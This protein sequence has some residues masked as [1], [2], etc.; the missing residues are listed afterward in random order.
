MQPQH[1]RLLYSVRQRLAL[2]L[3][4][5]S[6]MV[7][8]LACTLMTS[9]S[10]LQTVAFTAVVAYLLSTVAFWWKKTSARSGLII[11]T[12][13]LLA[14]GAMGKLGE[15]TKPIIFTRYLD[16]F[17]LLL[18]I[19]LLRQV[20]DALRLNEVLSHLLVQHKPQQLTLLITGLTAFFTWPMSLGAI[21]LMLDSLKSVVVPQRNLATIVTRMVCITMVLMPTTI[22]AA[23]VWSAMPGLSL[24]KAALFG[25]PL[26]L[27]SIILNQRTPVY[28]VPTESPPTSQSSQTWHIVMF[29]G[30]F[31][32]IFLTALLVLRL[33]AL[34]SIALTS[35]AM[36]VVVKL[37]DKRDLLTDG[38]TTAAQGIS[39]EML[40]LLACSLLSTTCL[41]FIPA[42]PDWFG[43]ELGGLMDWQ[44]YAI[45][46][47]VLPMFGVLG[48]HPLILF[49]LAWSIFS[50]YMQGGIADY[51]VWICLFIATQL[52]SPVSINS[53]FAAN[54][55]QVSTLETSF[56]MHTRYV[57]LFNTFALIY[58]SAIPVIL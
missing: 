26:F 46:L 17:W 6:L 10:G 11:F 52:L 4:A 29:I 47:F 2:P 21:P 1:I 31:W 39:G 19:G 49:S 30:L 7:L 43:Q 23:A 38:L 28:A 58:L 32:S 20:M 48:L 50:P 41:L 9:I 3:A 57:L 34:Q 16:V 12:F 42:L 51:Q 33:N 36:F 25:I 55:L 14:L 5:V 27:F 37:T 53:V 24:L 15:I 44:R 45:I 54:S 22:G 18:G 13:C 35:G 56:R 40:L 8:L